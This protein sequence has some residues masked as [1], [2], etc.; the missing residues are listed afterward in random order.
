METPR[1]ARHMT[2]YG[3]EM[4]KRDQIRKQLRPLLLRDSYAIPRSDPTPA[5]SNCIKHGNPAQPRQ[6]RSRL[7]SDFIP[8]EDSEL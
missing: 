4:S 2:I 7:E 8:E 6:M 5:F 3:N 1:A